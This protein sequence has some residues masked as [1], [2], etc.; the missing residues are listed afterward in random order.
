[1]EST[2]PAASTASDA[3]EV[4]NPP[5]VVFKSRGMRAKANIRKRPAPAPVAA[6]TTGASD[7]SSDDSDISS[8]EGPS[9]AKRRRR[10]N[11]GITSTSTDKKTADTTYSSTFEADRKVPLTDT[12]DATKRSDWYDEPTKKGPVKAATNVR[13]TITTDFAPDVCK[14]YKKTG[15]CGFGDSCVFLHDRSDMKQGWQLDREWETVAKGRNDLGG[16]V[17]S[18]AAQKSKD[19]ANGR[20]SKVGAGRQA[21][22]E[23]EDDEKMLEKIPFVCIICEKPY[24]SPVVTRCGHYFCEPCALKRYREDPSCKNCGAATGGVFNAATRLERLLKRKR[25]RESQAET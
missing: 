21:Q 6:A 1:M 25:E 7:R 9:V 14:D 18:S 2:T 22:D 3:G 4:A 13:M 16:T 10:D 20:I 11:R 17:V 5:T 15:W 8:D 23:E 19:K 24:R 12:N